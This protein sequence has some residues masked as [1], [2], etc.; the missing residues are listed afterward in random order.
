[1]LLFFFPF[2]FFGSP[3]PWNKPGSHTI[4]NFFFT[5][6]PS[7]Y[8]SFYAIVHF[9]IFA[10][11]RTCYLSSLSV[12]YFFIYYSAFHWLN[13]WQGNVSIYR[14]RTAF[15]LFIIFPGEVYEKMGT[16]FI[17]KSPYICQ[18][19]ILAQGVILRDL[20]SDWSILS[21]PLI[22]PVIGWFVGC[23]FRTWD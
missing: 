18:G 1:M 12:P 10:H 8:I 23:N 11:F 19:G 15:I 17:L 3:F 7:E 9:V 4:V 22:R 16:F 21:S 2:L 5:E 6:F 20:L 13:L 14:F